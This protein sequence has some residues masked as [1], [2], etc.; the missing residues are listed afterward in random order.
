M[1]NLPKT[2]TQGFSFPVQNLRNTKQIIQR[3]IR[4]VKSNDPRRKVVHVPHR[5]LF[6]FNYYTCQ[7]FR[8]FFKFVKP[9]P[10]TMVISLQKIGCCATA[11][12]VRKQ[13]A[14][15]TTVVPAT[16]SGLPRRACPAQ[17]HD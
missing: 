6:K 2:Q 12:G 14:P 17:D 10:A 3:T 11:M 13:R 4:T 15:F 7:F 16:G 9:P 8:A 1:L 5:T